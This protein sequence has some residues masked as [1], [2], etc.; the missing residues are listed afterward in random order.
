MDDNAIYTK[1]RI[2]IAE[3]WPHILSYIDALEGQINVSLINDTPQQTLVL[4]N[5]HLSSCYNRE[6]EAQTQNSTIPTS[7]TK[8]HLYGI[9]LGDSLCN[10]LERMALKELHVHILSPTVFYLYINFY[11]ATQCLSDER[12]HLQLAHEEQLEYPYAVN[13]G[14]LPFCEDKA[15]AIKN[16]IE[17]DRNEANLKRRHQSD[18]LPLYKTNMLQNQSF[19][20]EDPYIETLKNKHVGKRF[21]LIAGGPTASEQFSWLIQQRNEFIIIAA[22]T[23][24]VA[25]EA[26]G[27]IPDYVVAID[28]SPIL[29][30][31]F[32]VKDLK[33]YENIVLVFAPSTSYEVVA[34]WPG[35]RKIS[36]SA[37]EMQ[38]DLIKK[39]PESV[40]YSGGSVAHTTAALAVLLGAKE[41]TLIGFDFCFAYGESHLQ[42]NPLKHNIP[43][44]TDAWVLNGN[45]QRV[46]SQLNLVSYKNAMEEFI[47]AHPNVRFYNSGREGAEIKGAE[48]I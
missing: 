23:A 32:K 3:K 17:I 46:A 48:W 28:P 39:H 29:T 8:A 19:L 2:L 10:L 42:N 7:A 13:A 16:L 34:L 41:I 37:T 43:K 12:I 38:Q 35:I 27:I 26:V 33:S 21:A 15:L 22:S 14:E 11:D 31:H 47:A 25:L 6:K 18:W 24:L 4:N 36:L 20:D 45:N 5:L 30:T 9:G 1:N 44:V 40:L